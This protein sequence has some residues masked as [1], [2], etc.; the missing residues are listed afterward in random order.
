MTEQRKNGNGSERRS[1][2]T[3]TAIRANWPILLAVIAGVMGYQAVKDQVEDNTRAVGLHDKLLNREAF[4]EFAVWKTNTKRDIEQL[5]GH[6]L[7]LRGE[8]K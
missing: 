4:T 2:P 6:I 3:V 1:D 7:K 5:K 8:C